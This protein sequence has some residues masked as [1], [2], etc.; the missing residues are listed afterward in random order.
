M[1][2]NL[3]LNMPIYLDTNL[4][5]DLLASID[6]GFSAAKKI[7]TDEVESQNSYNRGHIGFSAYLFDFGINLSKDS[8]DTQGKTSEV[9]KYHTY[10]SMMNKLIGYLDEDDL[11]KKI[12]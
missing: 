4:L 6:D 8:S 5:L 12:K 2:S 11:I 1:K 9:K 3:E 10:G 7:T